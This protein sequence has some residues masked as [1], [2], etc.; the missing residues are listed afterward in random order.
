MKLDPVVKKEVR[1]MAEASFVCAVLVQIGFLVLRRWDSTVVLGGVLGFVMC[2][3][4]FFLMS[5]G[6]QRAVADPDPQHAQLVMKASYTRRSLLLLAVMVVSFVVEGIHWLPVVAAAFY[7]PVVI[8]ARQLFV[9][10]V[11]KKQDEPMPAA[12]GAIPEE[13]DE[14]EAYEEDEFEKAIGRFAGEIDTDYLK[15]TQTE[16]AQTSEKP[17]EKE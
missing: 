13:K 9:K 14:D 6:V 11:L 2:V 10:Y 12:A 1:F 8:F 15:N 16:D 4:N 7:P 3:L 17:K 5:V